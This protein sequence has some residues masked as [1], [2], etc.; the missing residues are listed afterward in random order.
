[1]KLI[2]TSEREIEGVVYY[3]FEFEVKTKYYERHALATATI[4]NEKFYAVVTGANKK[5]WPKMEGKLKT[6]IKSFQLT[7]PDVD[8]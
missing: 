3:Q 6:V 7:S 5:R 2:A 1:M 4:G 8:V